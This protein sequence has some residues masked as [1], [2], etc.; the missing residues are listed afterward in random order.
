MKPIRRTIVMRGG[1]AYYRKRYM[2][3]TLRGLR[4][5]FNLPHNG[6]FRVVIKEGGPYKIVKNCC[7]YR[8]STGGEFCGS[9]CKD[10]FH[11]LF[12]KP[13]G[14]KRYSIQIKILNRR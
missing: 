5:A 13:D 10:A 3:V 2:G 4:E 11:Q 12:F 7:F 1:F 8:I 6:R 9:I 14:R